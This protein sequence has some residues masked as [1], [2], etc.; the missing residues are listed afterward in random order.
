MLRFLRKRA[1]AVAS[2]CVGS[3]FTI[4]IAD[5]LFNTWI[6]DEIVGLAIATILFAVV[7]VLKRTDAHV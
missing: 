4:T 5:F 7:Y 1:V 6:I 3:M 2:W